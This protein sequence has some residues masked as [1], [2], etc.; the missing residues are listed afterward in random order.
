MPDITLVFQNEAPDGSEI[1]VNF[2]VHAGREVTQAEIDRLA[3]QLLGEAESVTVV[4]E[5]RYSFDSEAEAVVHQVR[6]ELPAGRV[7]SSVT[8]TVETWARDCIG[9]RS[10][11][12]E[13]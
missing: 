12:G 3:R 7:D 5:N 8:D 2:G 11:L 9:E 4:S 10:L 1:T 13:Q 6:I